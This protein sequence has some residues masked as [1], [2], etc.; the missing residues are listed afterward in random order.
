[1]SK[2]ANSNQPDLST[3]E[4]IKQAARAVFHRKGYSATKTRDIAEEAGM[5]LALLNYYFR[6]KEK[7]FEQIMFET[8]FGF[9]QNMAM[10]FNDE[11]TTL[12][13][14]VELMVDR[15]IDMISREPEIPLFI[16]SEIRS[17]AGAFLEKVPLGPMIVQSV[18]VRQYQKL[19]EE[20]KAKEPDPL[21]F[22]MNLLALVVFPF[23]A[24]PLLKKI[25]NLKEKQF[26][27]M[28]QERKRMIPLW[29][30]AMLKA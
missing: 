26:D 12:H 6:S 13:Q 23:M 16:M 20:G 1:M 30:K 24:S 28:M 17:N 3:E 5:N 19:V 7:L 15:Y 10:V 27:N 2:K 4:R 8:V 9:M 14:K 18:F 29:I 11:H 22:L 21:Q 25:G